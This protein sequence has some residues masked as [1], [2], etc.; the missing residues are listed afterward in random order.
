[1][2]T[3]QFILL[4]ILV[5]LLSSCGG[6]FNNFNRQKH[7]GLKSLPTAYQSQE[8]NEKKKT[9]S[10]VSKVAETFEKERKVLEVNPK[11]ENIK[12]AISN[13]EPVII[14]KGDEYYLIENPLYDQFYN[15][16]FGKFTQ[17]KKEDL[18]DSWLQLGISETT[19]LNDRNGLT[20]NDNVVIEK[21]YS[22]KEVVK[23][24]SPIEHKPETVAIPKKQAFKI[25]N[26][27]K[28]WK[29]TTV[30]DVVASVHGRR[31]RTAYA[32]V[33]LLVGLGVFLTLLFFV[34]YVDFFLIIAALAFVGAFI[35][36]LIAAV[37]ARKFTR[38][39]Y[40]KKKKLHN[41]FKLM[42]FLIWLG[43]LVFSL[44]LFPIFLL[45]IAAT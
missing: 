9:E 22:E 29:E 24:Y 38:E 19:A 27:D 32:T 14:K 4:G 17:V 41:S 33:F 20:V 5:A 36:L 45:L 7:T 15:K 11:V 31:A 37:S 39:M 35:S 40:Y 12:K 25:Y 30:R 21:A 43:I 18:G 28:T 42:K 16:L 10:P 13:N 3:K 8:K 23:N 1:M 6:G 26:S 44:I 34:V 2:K